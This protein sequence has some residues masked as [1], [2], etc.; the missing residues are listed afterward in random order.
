M[1]TEQLCNYIENKN[2]LD[3]QQEKLK[4]ESQNLGSRFDTIEDFPSM[5]DIDIKAIGQNKAIRDS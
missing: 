4:I 5:Y 2:A 1:S 3:K